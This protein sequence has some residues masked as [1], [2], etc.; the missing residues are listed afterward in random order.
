LFLYHAY[1]SSADTLRQTVFIR[2]PNANFA[3]NILDN[4]DQHRANMW[5]P[6]G[7]APANGTAFWRESPNQRGTLNILSICIITLLLCAY[8]SL[9]LDIPRYGKAGWVHQIWR[10]LLWVCVGLAAPEFVSLPG[11][12]ATPPR[13]EKKRKKR[14][15]KTTTL[16]LTYA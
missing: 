7:L 3:W 9:H 12:K 4:S 15:R 14:K 5:E 2:S 1:C 10:R 11:C 6:F 16:V 8:T 13:K